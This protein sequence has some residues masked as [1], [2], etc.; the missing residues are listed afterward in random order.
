M[1]YQ[2]LT[3]EEKVVLVGQTVVLGTP[4]TAPFEETL[5]NGTLSTNPWYISSSGFV[6]AG[7]LT[8]GSSFGVDVVSEDGGMF[9]IFDAYGFGGGS[10]SLQVPKMTLQELDRSLF[11]TSHSSLRRRRFAQYICFDRRSKLHP[12][13]EKALTDAPQGWVEYEV[14]LSAYQDAPW[15]SINFTG[16]VSSTSCIFIDYIRVEKSWI[17]NIMVS[18]F[19]GPSKLAAGQEGT[20]NVQVSNKGSEA[21]AFTVNLSVDGAFVEAQQQTKLLPRARQH[22]Y[23]SRI[24]PM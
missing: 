24:L 14:D 10:A 21:A 6:T 8:D 12:L 23:R 17:N 20:F 9:G 3:S 15:I 16:T 19:E 1:P 2:H 7:L 4:Y 5:A 11:S 22:P 13:F 18:K